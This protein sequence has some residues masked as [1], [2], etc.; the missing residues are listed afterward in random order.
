MDE[1]SQLASAGLAIALAAVLLLTSHS[2]LKAQ[3]AK[4]PL[5]IASDAFALRPNQVAFYQARGF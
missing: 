5:V 2:F 3:A 1:V 4:H